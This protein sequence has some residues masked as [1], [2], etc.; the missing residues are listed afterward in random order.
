MYGRTP[1][2]LTVL[3]WAVMSNRNHYFSYVALAVQPY[4]GLAMQP[5]IAN[6]CIVM[7]AVQT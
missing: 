3:G 7:F 1:K 2:L 5:A 6:H 4:T